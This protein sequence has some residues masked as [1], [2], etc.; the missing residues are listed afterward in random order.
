[1][2]TVSTPTLHSRLAGAPF[3]GLLVKIVALIAVIV[4][5]VVMS[6]TAQGWGESLGTPHLHAADDLHAPGTGHG[7]AD[8]R[9]DASVVP[10]FVAAAPA[11]DVL[12]AGTLGGVVLVAS[13]TLMLLAALG[14]AILRAL[15]GAPHLDDPLGRRLRPR[16]AW[17]AAWLPSPPTPAALSV[18]RI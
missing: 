7:V 18:F 4:G 1:M 15:R 13:A 2:V 5:L 14:V 8:S 6:P 3:L 10:A 16:V 11:S 9:T 12:F 17:D